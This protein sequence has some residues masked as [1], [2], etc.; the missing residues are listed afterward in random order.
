MAPV[1]RR[2][3]HGSVPNLTPRHCFLQT[4]FSVL[5]LVMVLALM[6]TFVGLVVPSLAQPL[7]RQTQAA[8]IHQLYG[9]L[10]QARFTAINE[11]ATVTACPSAS[12]DRCDDTN[13]WHNG[14]MVFIDRT[15]HHRPAIPDAVLAVSQGVATGVITSGGRHRIRFDPQGNAYGSN[16]TIAHCPERVQGLSHEIVISNPGRIRFV[17][18]DP[19]GVCHRL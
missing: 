14:W 13:Q 7:D 8:A 11:N 16:G 12:G 6:A 4:G 9:H 17:E 10:R 5:E 15:R 18:L 3:H 2:C 19:M 1:W